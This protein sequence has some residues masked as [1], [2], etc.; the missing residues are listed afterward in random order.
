MLTNNLP[1]SPPGVEWH[2]AVVEHM[3][4]GKVAVFLLQEEDERVHHVDDLGDVEHPGHGQRSQCLRGHGVIHGLTPP[5]VA[6]C[7]EEAGQKDDIQ[8][9]CS[10][11]DT[12]SLEESPIS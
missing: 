6:S 2:D 10:N 12:S 8:C 5:T 1:G 3:K 9:Y 4:K 11:H 7:H